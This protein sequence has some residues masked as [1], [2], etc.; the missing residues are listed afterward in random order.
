MMH[1]A[2]NKYN[3]LFYL[4]ILATVLSFMFSSS[5]IEK[6][7]QLISEVSIIILFLLAIYRF[8]VFNNTKQLPRILKIWV[9]VLAII[10][11]LA[12]AVPDYAS[13][14][15]WGDLRETFIPF[16]ITFSAFFLFQ[17]SD[18]QLHGWLLF[19][20]CISAI[21]AVYILSR[22]GGFVVLNLYRD[23]VSK[24]QF[25]PFF[26]QMSLISFSL[27]MH[28][29]KT[30]RN[31]LCI[32]IFLCCTGFCFFV[33]AR[34][35]LLVT[36]LLAFF[37]LYKR[38]H[39]K[40]LL[41][42]PLALAVIWPFWGD[43]IADFLMQSIVGNYNVMDIDSLT[44]G[45]ASR[46]EAAVHF[47]G[48]NPLIGALGI[49]NSPIWQNSF[50]IPHLYLFWKLVK[51]GIIIGLPFCVVYFSVGITAIKMI[52]K[53]WD[54]TALS[55]VCIAVAF[56]TSLTEYSSPFGPGTSY[57]VAY[58]LLGRS[59]AKISQGNRRY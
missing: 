45:R 8:L 36:I 53:N 58:I 52:F 42:F 40:A 6:V 19:L 33:R 3:L 50:Q 34:T 44:T 25:A 38:Y 49:P 14:S 57:I 16:A 17:E 30:W 29:Q 39:A 5:P 18:E 7:A 37:L 9:M 43:K 15:V 56:L 11:I 23:D 46:N 47:I 12:I 59:L 22:T 27:I 54:E 51:Y 24:N 41:L 4:A 2:V 35:G 32:V 1:C 48:E 20:C 55:S 26:A 31:I 28:G 10:L 21:A 13:K